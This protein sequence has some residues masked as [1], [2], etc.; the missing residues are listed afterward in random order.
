ECLEYVFYPAFQPRRVHVS[1]ESVGILLPAHREKAIDGSPDD[2]HE[3][4]KIALAV[5]LIAH[6]RQR[7]DQDAGA[8]A[9]RSNDK[10]RTFRH[11]CTLT[12]HPSAG[13]ILPEFSQE[14][15]PICI[16]VSAIRSS[17]SFVLGTTR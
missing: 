17:R 4:Q 2:H 13:N 1:H 14:G 15:K 12:C 16:F 8:R 10:N 7:C 3:G 9:G 5:A 6:P 11:S